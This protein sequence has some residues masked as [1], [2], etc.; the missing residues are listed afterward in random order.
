MLSR[1]SGSLAASESAWFAATAADAADQ[2]EADHHRDEGRRDAAQAPV[3][4]AAHHR[5]EQEATAGSRARAGSAPRA[6]GTGSPPRPAARRATERPAT[7]LR[8]ANSSSERPVTSYSWP[9]GKCGSSVRVREVGVGEQR[10]AARRRSA[11][12]SLNFTTSCQ[13]LKMMSSV[14]SSPRWRMP[15]VCARPSSSMP[16]QRVL[17]SFHCSSRISSPVVL[18]QVTS[19]TPSSSLY[20]PVRKRVRRRIG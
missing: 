16:K 17:A 12:G 1:Y 6:R 7:W 14:A 11:C 15:V 10:P 4:Q 9:I 5:R 18:I 3:L 8:S 20:S 13:G 19:L 2:R